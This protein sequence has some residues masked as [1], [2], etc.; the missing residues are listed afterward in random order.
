MDLLGMDQAKS[1]HVA[2]LVQLM[3]CIYIYN[4]HTLIFAHTHTHDIYIYNIIYNIYIY[5]IIY[6]IIYIYIY[7][8]IYTN[9]MYDVSNE[10]NRSSFPPTVTGW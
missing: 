5:N 3:Y 8:C 1:K 4:I 7:R 2:H 6:N 10:K 9:I